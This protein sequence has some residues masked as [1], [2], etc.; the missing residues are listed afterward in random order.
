MKNGYVPRMA[1]MAVF[2]FLF[3]SSFLITES[4]AHKWVIYNRLIT[5]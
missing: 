2:S 5:L 1:V 4:H 3:I